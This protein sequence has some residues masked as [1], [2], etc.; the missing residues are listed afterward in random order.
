[1]TLNELAYDRTG[2]HDHESAESERSAWLKNP[3]FTLAF[4]LVSEGFSV[5]PLCRDGKRPTRK[6]KQYQYR[7]PT[8]AEMVEWFV[9]NDFCP[10]IVTGEISGI[11]VIDCDS[12]D[13]IEAMLAAGTESRLTQSTKRGRHFIFRHSGERNTVRVNGIQGVDRRGEGGYVKAYPD[14]GNWTREDVLLSP[15]L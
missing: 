14:S 6:W 1:M 12:I 4:G 13:A 5:I 15:T 9:D 8:A 2:N 10:A 3:R 7:Q 11:T